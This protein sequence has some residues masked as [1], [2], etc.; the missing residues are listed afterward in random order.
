MRSAYEVPLRRQQRTSDTNAINVVRYD[1]CLLDYLIQ[2]RTRTMNHNWVQ[3]N[4]V[5]EAQAEGEL[6]E[7]AKDSTADFDDS[8]LGG[9]RRVRRRG[10]DTQVTLHLAFRTDRVQK[11]G[12]RFLVPPR[13][14]QTKENFPKKSREEKHTLSVCWIDCVCNARTARGARLAARTAERLAPPTTIAREALIADN[15]S[16]PNKPF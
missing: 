10:E 2:L 4:A 15:I 3:P 16:L 9:M 6:V 1:S 5:Q 12:N 8:E 13:P 11:A 14:S 7:F